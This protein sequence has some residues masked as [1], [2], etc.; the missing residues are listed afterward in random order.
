M[1]GLR[2]PYFADDLE[3]DFQDFLVGDEQDP[4]ALVMQEHAREGNIPIEQHAP[5]KCLPPRQP[6][7]LR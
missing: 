4:M 7:L 3:N 6:K 1:M 2:P 5:D